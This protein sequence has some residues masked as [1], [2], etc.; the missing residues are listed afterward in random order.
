MPNKKPKDS[1]TQ[2]SRKKR[3][4][5]FIKRNYIFLSPLFIGLYPAVFLYSQNISEYPERMLQ[6]PLILSLIVIVVIFGISKVI[7]KKIEI[8]SLV[9]AVFIF[10][11][12]SY[13]KIYDGFEALQL[14]IGSFNVSTKLIYLLTVFIILGIFIFGVIKFR[15]YSLA[16][17]KVFTI[18]SLALLI[19]AL[20]P[21]IKFEVKEGRVFRRVGSVRIK[22]TRTV[23]PA[24]NAPDIYYIMPEDYGGQEALQ[25]QYGFDNSSFLKDLE[26]RG[27][28]VPSKSTANYPKTFL[29]LASSMNYEYVNFLTDQTHGGASSDESVVT[30]LIQNNKVIQFLKNKGYTY[31]HMGSWWEPTATNPNADK[32]F[33]VYKGSYWGS[34]E[35]TT[36]FISD[37]A[38]APVLNRIRKNPINVS[39]DPRN[40]DHRRR[41]FYEFQ[42]GTDVIPQLPGPKFVFIHIMAP[43]EPFVV[44]KNCTPLPE[45]VVTKRSL[46]DNNLEQIQCVNKQLLKMIDSIISKSKTPPVILLQ[47]DEGQFPINAPLTE[48]ESWITA[49]DQAL[50]EKFPILNAYYL[51]KGG[52]SLLYP[53]IT[54]VNS[55]RVVFNKY[56]NANLPLLPDKNYIFQDKDNLYKFTDVTTKVRK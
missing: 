20:F 55:F 3:L 4:I 6:I 33:V 5:G 8:A 47:S 25:G 24:E 14:H 15:K 54:P 56:F 13:S 17:N 44:D 18:I 43:H 32:N 51:P 22:E 26:K 7:F 34:D 52:N 49:N 11:F 10:V 27:F 42:T 9:A 39:D 28:Y 50:D 40:N 53:S 30:P 38:A 48:E 46:K 37:T 2:I 29:S 23:K 45:S 36:G 16:L 35:F 31:I 41:M 12:L 19:F 1:K 21:I